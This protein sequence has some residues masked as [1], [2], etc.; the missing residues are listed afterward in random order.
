MFD[1]FSYVLLVPPADSFA[2]EQKTLNIMSYIL[3]LIISLYLFVCLLFYCLWYHVMDIVSQI[4]LT[5]RRKSFEFEMT[6]SRAWTILWA[7]VRFWPN[8]AGLCR[9][10]KSVK[11]NCQKK[12]HV[13]L[14]SKL[15]SRT[16]SI[17]KLQIVFALFSNNV[18]LW[19][20]KTNIGPRKTK[21]EEITD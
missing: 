13:E 16:W 5:W 4:D 8:R 20:W 2:S 19:R 14:T 17:N 3:Y 12:S 10:V 6:K 9:L 18:C 15:Q 21:N 7:W 11:R 1:Y